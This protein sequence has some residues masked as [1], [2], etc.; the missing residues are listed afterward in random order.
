MN[1]SSANLKSG[2]KFARLTIIEFSHR[3]KKSR[4]F[5]F[6]LCDCGTV[7]TVNGILLVRGTTRS[8]GC[9]NKEYRRFIKL[10]N[11]QGVINSIILGYKR[12]ADER[13]IEWNLSTE[14]ATSLINKP[15]FYCGTLA[16]NNKIT[17]SC[18]DGYKHNGIDRVD[19]TKHYSPDNVVPCC[20]VCNMAKRMH[21]QADF[22]NWIKR[23][24][25]HTFLK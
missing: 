13:G 22:L 12:H 3:D 19:P 24:Y 1:R 4:V 17:K 21:P 6:V 15:C 2:E 18:K 9:L 14:E 10:P 20:K 5:Y 7:K 16:S 11:N 8:C 23:V 25:E